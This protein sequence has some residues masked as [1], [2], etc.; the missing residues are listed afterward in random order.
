MD[1]RGKLEPRTI[2]TT[3]YANET[4]EMHRELDGSVPLPAVFP[5]DDL[6]KPDPPHHNRLNLFSTPAVSC[7][8]Y[9]EL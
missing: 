9:V 6:D 3:Y 2:N 1:E 4:F 7:T 5:K 8:M